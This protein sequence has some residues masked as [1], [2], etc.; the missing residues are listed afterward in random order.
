MSRQISVGHAQIPISNYLVLTRYD[1]SDTVNQVKSTPSFIFHVGKAARYVV[2]LA[3]VFL[4]IL[5]PA[6]DEHGNFLVHYLCRGK[7]SDVFDAK[8]HWIFYQLL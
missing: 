2:K 5:T 3:S 8:K 6:R 1:F 4:L 7:F